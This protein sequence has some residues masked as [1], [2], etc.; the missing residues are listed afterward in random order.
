M[1]RKTIKEISNEGLT[2][3]VW[4]A[5]EARVR[6]RQVRQ[7]AMHLRRMGRIRPFAILT[8]IVPSKTGHIQCVGGQRYTVGFETTFKGK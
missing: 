8:P 2:D 6:R 3:E 1:A 7:E 4:D 5:A